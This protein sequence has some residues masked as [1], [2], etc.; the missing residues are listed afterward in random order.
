[1]KNKRKANAAKPD[2]IRRNVSA[3]ATPKRT[4]YKTQR[5]S[6]PTE[7]DSCEVLQRNRPH[8]PQHPTL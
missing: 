5:D 4:S 1:M 6:I 8:P 7:N 2:C 3:S